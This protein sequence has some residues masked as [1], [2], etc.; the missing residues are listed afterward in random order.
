MQL[1]YLGKK[2]AVEVGKPF[3][4]RDYVFHKNSEAVTV[5]DISAK[6]LIET[7]PRMFDVKPDP[8][9]VEPAEIDESNFPD[10]D[11]DKSLSKSALSR[12]RKPDIVEALDKHF[13]LV[14]DED[15]TRNE[16]IDLYVKASEPEEAEKEEPEE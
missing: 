13:G 6:K 16:L 11:E 1:T 15:F 9:H 7:N 3:L 2:D 8:V 14:Y 4:P 12:M 10:E 5:D